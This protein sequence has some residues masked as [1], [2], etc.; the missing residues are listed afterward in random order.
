MIH[1]TVGYFAYAV[2]PKRVILHN[3]DLPL[4]KYRTRQRVHM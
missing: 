3:L 1:V 4:L 2:C